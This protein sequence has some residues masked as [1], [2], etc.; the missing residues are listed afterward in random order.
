LATRDGAN[1]LREPVASLGRP[2]DVA[3]I[4][5]GVALGGLFSE[6][7][8]GAELNMIALNCAGTVQLAKLVVPNDKA[9]RE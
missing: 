1:Q 6:M 8:V 7:D 5:A 4:N 9:R 3:C 2:V